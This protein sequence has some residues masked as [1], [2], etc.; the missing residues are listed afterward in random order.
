MYNWR[1]TESSTPR[2]MKIQLSICK[3]PKANLSL[4]WTSSDLKA[5]LWPL[6]TRPLYESMNMVHWNYEIHY[7]IKFWYVILSFHDFLKQ[8]PFKYVLLNPK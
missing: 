6:L 2:I 7:S 5:W 4:I 3:N 1:Y 8:I